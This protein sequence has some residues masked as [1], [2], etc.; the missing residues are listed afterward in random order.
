MK[1]LPNR[2]P[3]KSIP[4][5]IYID[6]GTD[7]IMNTTIAHHEIRLTIRHSQETDFILCWKDYTMHVLVERSYLIESAMESVFQLTLVVNDGEVA[8]WVVEKEHF[9]HVRL[10]DDEILERVLIHVLPIALWFQNLI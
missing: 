7:Y 3:C 10:V 4:W 1:N 8:Y 6:N 2:V 5:I 9:I